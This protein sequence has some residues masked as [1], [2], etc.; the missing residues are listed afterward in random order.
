MADS[1]RAL[2]DGLK[3]TTEALVDAGIASQ[4][5]IAASQQAIH[6][7]QRAGA[8]VTKM[9]DAAVDAWE[10]HEDLRETVARLESLVVAQGQ[11]LRALRER[12]DRGGS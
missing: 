5:A 2:F 8:E 1:S 10:E 3:A 4:Q 9:A 12:L 6:A 11:D 7:L